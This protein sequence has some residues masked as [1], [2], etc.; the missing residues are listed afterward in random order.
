MLAWGTPETPLDPRR[1][2][3]FFAEPK[4]THGARNADQASPCERLQSSQSAARAT[5]TVAIAAHSQWLFRMTNG[6]NRPGADRV[7]CR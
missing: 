3:D 4:K 2:N 5:S 6:R 1:L 7:A